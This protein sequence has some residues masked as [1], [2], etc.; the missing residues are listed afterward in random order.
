MSI[1]DQIQELVPAYIL[2]ALE[3]EETTQ[4]ESHLRGC[5]ECRHVA[6]EYG[7]VREALASNV[8]QIAPPRDLKYRTMRRVQSPSL[9]ENAHGRVLAPPRFSLT[10]LFAGAALA[11]ALLVL[12]VDV[13][14]ANQMD[15]ELAMQRDLITVIAYSEG[16]VQTVRGTAAAPLAIGKFYMDRDA[17]VAALITVNMPALDSAHSYHVW[18]SEAGGNLVSAG[19]FRVN[20]EGNGWLLL[21]APKP[22]AAYTSVSVSVETPGQVNTSSGQTI[23][24]AMLQTP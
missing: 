21:R 7:V 1:H 17:N 16:S 15:H 8:P 22:L 5:A 12:G 14:Q 9:Q 2:H 23:L 24:Q 18:L 13:W 6:E 11:I 3:A 19:E 10:R 4:V 20:D